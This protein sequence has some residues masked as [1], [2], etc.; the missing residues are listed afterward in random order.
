MHAK[1]GHPLP[2]PLTRTL[3][4][5]PCSTTSAPNPNPNPNPHPHPNPNDTLLDQVGADLLTAASEGAG[6]LA[7]LCTSRAG[8]AACL[9]AGALPLLLGGLC[10]LE[11]FWQ[12]Q[13]YTDYARDDFGIAPRQGSAGVLDLGEI[14]QRWTE[15]HKQESLRFCL[16]ALQALGPLCRAAQPLDWLTLGRV[17]LRCRKLAETCVRLVGPH[18]GSQLL[19]LL[20]GAAARVLSHLPAAEVAAAAG[21]EQEAARAAELEGILAERCDGEQRRERREKRMREAEQMREV[22]HAEHRAKLR[23]WMEG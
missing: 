5:T 14:R 6:M 17:A 20:R 2:L 15:Q 8:T 3:T 19:L 10:R 11:T 4:L 22:A 13:L 21:S 7:A 9:A 23:K 1:V 16:H 18:W 12:I